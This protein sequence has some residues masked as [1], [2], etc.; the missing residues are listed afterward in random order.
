MPSYDEAMVFAREDYADPA[1]L[2]EQF[3]ANDRAAITTH[4]S[5]SPTR[6]DLDEMGADG[7]ADLRDGRLAA[8]ADYVLSLDRRKGAWYWLLREQPELERRDR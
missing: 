8:L 6:A 5:V 2:P 3:S 4:L 1:L 7:R